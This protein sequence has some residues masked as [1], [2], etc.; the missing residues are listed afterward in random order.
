MG[1]WQTEIDERDR[2][3]TAFV[4]R[5]GEWCFK[6]LSFGLC[7]TP[8]QFARIM[9]LVMSGLTYEE[10]LVYLDDILLFSRTFEEHCDRLATI[11]DG[12][13]R[14]SLKLKPTKCHLFQRRVTFLGHVVSASGIECGPGKVAAIAEWPRPTNVT[15]VRSFCGLASYYTFLPNFA[16]IAKPLHELTRKGIAFE[17]GASQEAAFQELKQCLT[18]APILV[19]PCDEG[20]YTLD[21]DVS[22]AALGTV[23]QQEQDG[24]LK[25]I[26]YAS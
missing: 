19:A 15:E 11:F 21:T 1:Y 16:T 23:L 20:R 22:E 4:T 12:L 24:Q 25:V 17:W 13:E 6:V 26:A 3:K 14:H 8:S 5:K 7:N 2:D 18:S 9:E 10:C